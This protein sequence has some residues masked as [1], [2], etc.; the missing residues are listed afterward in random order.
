MKFDTDPE[1]LKRQV[2]IETYRS[3]GPGG[4]RLKIES[5]PLKDFADV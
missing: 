5:L 3:R 2:T 1:I 4:P